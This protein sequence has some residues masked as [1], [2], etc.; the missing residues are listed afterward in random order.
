MAATNG[1][2]GG[3]RAWLDEVQRQVAEATRLLMKGSLGWGLGVEE[4]V[5][6]V[7]VGV[8]TFYRVHSPAT[9]TTAQMCVT[10]HQAITILQAKMESAAAQA[11][12]KDA[13][14]PAGEA[15]GT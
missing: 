14:K 11:I 9:T 15:A 1:M 10:M 8:A 13:E 4:T 12:E 7:L 3:D 6:G 2:G 5:Y